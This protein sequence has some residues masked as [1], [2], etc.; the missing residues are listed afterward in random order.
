M[1]W[2]EVWTRTVITHTHTHKLKDEFSAVFLGMTNKIGSHKSRKSSGTVIRKCIPLIAQ[3]NNSLLK[4][5]MPNFLLLSCTVQQHNQTGLS[6]HIITGTHSA[7]YLLHAGFLFGLFCDLKME[8]ILS[9]ET[10]VDFN[11]LHGVI[12]QTTEFFITTGENTKSYLMKLLYHIY[13]CTVS[14]PFYKV[15]LKVKFHVDRNYRGDMTGK[16]DLKVG[17]RTIH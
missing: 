1:I 11:G 9:A 8:A 4:P 17:S 6:Q 15:A 16:F 7:W 13:F 3:T 5:S 12:F 2:T 14:I 10:F